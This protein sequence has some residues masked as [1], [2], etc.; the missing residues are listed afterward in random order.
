MH[1]HIYH[2]FLFSLLNQSR[3][4]VLIASILPL[5]LMIFFSNIASNLYHTEAH[6]VNYGDQQLR[7]HGQ[8][9]NSVQ[10]IFDSGSSYTYLPEEI[11]KSIVAA[12]SVVINFA[13]R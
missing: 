7:L 9:G 13:Y 12:V 1:C 6:N 10:V 8:A 11:Y 5:S 4:V 2:P 3:I